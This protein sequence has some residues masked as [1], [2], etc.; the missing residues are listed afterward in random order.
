MRDP[1]RGTTA[2]FCG[3]DLIWMGKLVN[4][5]TRLAR[6]SL[7]MKVFVVLPQPLKSVINGPSDPP[8]V[9]I[10]YL[11]DKPHKRFFQSRIGPMI[12]KFF[13][14]KDSF[15][16]YNFIFLPEQMYESWTNHFFLCSIPRGFIWYMSESALDLDTPT[17][18]YDMTLIG[19]I[20]K[21][22]GQFFWIFKTLSLLREDSFL[23]NKDYVVEWISI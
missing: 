3:Q 6:L 8:K 5:H 11:P 2:I 22:R 15:V 10:P 14:N 4:S 20:N 17:Y 21:P 12:R 1:L 18:Q 13:I 23:L 9:P 19:A 7:N 16:G